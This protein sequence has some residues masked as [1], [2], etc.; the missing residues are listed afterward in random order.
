MAAIGPVPFAGMLL[1]D[2]G[3]DIVRIDRPPHKGPPPYLTPLDRGRRSI[4][5]DLKSAGGTGVVLDLLS[6][7]DILLEGFR[8]GVMERLGLG[9]S[10]CLAV[11]P[12]LVY[13]RMTG[14]GQHGR[15]SALGGHDINYIALTGVL[16][17]IG[18]ADG[19][20]LPPQ[21]LLGDFGGGGMLL[22]VGVLSA[23]HHART[24]GRGQVIDAAMVDGAST[25]MAMHFGLRAQGVLGTRSDNG[26][27]GGSPYY[28]AYETADGGW[29][30]VGAIEEQFYVAMV[31]TLGLEPTS[32]PDRADHAQWPALRQ[33]LA[34]VFRSKRRDD[35]TKIF[36]AVDACVTPVLS[37]GEVETNE[38]HIE[39]GV[40]QEVD[41]VVQPA[42]APRMSE[43]PGAIQGPPPQPGEHTEQVLQDW[44]FAADA[45]RALR[46]GGAIW[47]PNAPGD[48][49]SRPI[50]PPNSL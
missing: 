10:E 6:K 41:G 4:A 44:G 2:L 35:W 45:I 1:S 33:R 20:P 26:L 11:N 28:C 31:T 39:R 15:L 36:A 8:P 43:T 23:L 32:L 16:D 22:A 24:A 47:G 29:M 17:L 37:L 48:P 7:A 13:G 18:E 25:L 34:E 5:V 30:A 21:N 9:P 42:P 19:P 3:A 12:K 50:D 14:F 49:S 27:G 38:F 40:F 46:D